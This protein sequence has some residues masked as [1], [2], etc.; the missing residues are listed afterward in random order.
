MGEEGALVS[1]C[2][3]YYYRRKREKGCERRKKNTYG[4]D[5]SVEE[6]ERVAQ[7]LTF[8]LRTYL[9]SSAFARKLTA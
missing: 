8:H 3:H 1:L 7:R 4:E 5:G 2:P 6:N 9:Y